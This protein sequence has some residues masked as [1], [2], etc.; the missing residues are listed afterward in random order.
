MPVAWGMSCGDDDDAAKD[1]LIRTSIH[2]EYDFGVSQ[3]RN[4]TVVY[5][6]LIYTRKIDKNSSKGDCSVSFPRGAK[7]RHTD[8]TYHA[9]ATADPVG[10]TPD[11][12]TGQIVPQC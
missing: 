1:H 5:L 11:C 9:A 6:E 12:L 3:D 8:T 2:D 4:R 7:Q 10:A